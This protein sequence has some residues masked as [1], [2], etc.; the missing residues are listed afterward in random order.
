MRRISRY[1]LTPHFF[2]CF[3]VLDYASRFPEAIAEMKAWI[4]QGQLKQSV[5]VIDGFENLPGALIKLFEGAN[6]GKLMVKTN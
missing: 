3:I 2:A 6:T 1:C 5:T 4:D